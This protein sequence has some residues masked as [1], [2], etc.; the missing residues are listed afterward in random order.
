ME[1]IMSGA[2][3]V[4]VSRATCLVQSPLCQD[5]HYYG[6]RRHPFCKTGGA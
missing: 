6:R 4:T 3:H 2:D 5:I 1:V